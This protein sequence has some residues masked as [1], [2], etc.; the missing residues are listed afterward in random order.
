M[1]KNIVIVGAGYAGVLTA[2]K[3]AKR[4][5]KQP[6]VK[7]TLID[8]HPYHTMLTELHEVAFNRVPGDSVRISLKKIFAGRKVDVVLDTITAVDYDKR[9]LTGKNGTYSY[10]YLVLSTG[11]KPTF[12][13]TPGAEEY[14]YKLWSF[15][16]AVLLKNRVID[17]FK[18]AVSET[19]DALKRRL[20]TFYI[21]GAGF[22]GVEAAGDLAEWVPVLCDEYE[23]ARELVRIVNV[24]MLDRAVPNFPPKVSAK[25][26]RRLKKMGVE[27]VLKTG[28]S[29][30]GETFIELKRGETLFREETATIIWTAGIEGSDVVK[31]ATLKKAGRERLQTDACL[32]AEGKTNVYVA[33]D[34]VFYV[35]EGEKAPV[36]QMVENAEQC[37]HTVANN[38]AAEITGAGTMEKYEPKFHGAM[39]SIGGRYAAAYVGTAKNKISLASF[40]AMFAKHFIN[41]IYFIQVLGWNKI[42]SYLGYEFF[43]IRNCRSFLG[44][45]FSNRTPSFLLVPLRVFLGAVWVYE[46]ILKISEGWLQSPK[47]A[48]Y[49]KGASDV[50]TSVLS[51]PGATDA[52][53]SATTAASGAA[54]APAASLIFNWNILGLFKVIAIQATDIAVKIQMGLMDW[55]TATFMTQTAGQQMFF[56]TLVVISEITVGVLLILGLFTFISSGY[57]IVLQSMFLMTTGMYMAQWWMIFAAFALLIGAGR[58]FGLDYYAMPFLKKHWKNVKIARKLYLYND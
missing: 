2:K 9:I 28:V 29:A 52:T 12:F 31:Q 50:F 51:N 33:G 20:L 19:D 4:L 40:F 34:N 17:L 46:G 10:D 41:V 5:K 6:D 25:A 15:D 54:A 47:L 22:T 57:S 58:T 43:K 44:G 32:R 21:V 38:I 16:D 36:P 45:H 8:K 35:P 23:I 49:F 13:G 11:S 14:S 30:V 55:F 37:A 18:Q 7:I 56:Q 53:S 27:V 42:A 39:L 1:D 24:D 26:E 3:L 48:A